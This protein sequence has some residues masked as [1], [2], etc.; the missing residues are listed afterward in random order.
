MPIAFLYIKHMQKHVHVFWGQWFKSMHNNEIKILLV[1]SPRLPYW[2]RDD[3]LDLN[4]NKL[5]LAQ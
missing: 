5:E 4:G 2:T 3:E 1:N